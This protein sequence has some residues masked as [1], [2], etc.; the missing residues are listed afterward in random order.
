MRRVLRHLFTLCSALSLLLC[1]AVCVMWV[2]SFFVG[3]YYYRSRWSFTPPSAVE[4]RGSW[5]EFALILISGRGTFSIAT[6]TQH[7]VGSSPPLPQ[8]GL[9]DTR[10]MKN[11]PPASAA[12]KRANDIVWRALGSG[13]SSARSR[14]VRF[15][16]QHRRLW[17]PAWFLALGTMVAP[18][19][20]LWRYVQRR[21][22]RGMN[23][24]RNCG[25]DLRASPER[26]PECG[27][28]CPA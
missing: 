24:C 15:A 18:S 14:G 25:Y 13:Y 5:D 11:Y 19:L 6:R 21:R 22:A 20:W 28:V 7:W 9:P 8:R 1:V 4:P 12:V 16:G 2:R 3:D 26:C 23:L 27:T 17:L 10:W